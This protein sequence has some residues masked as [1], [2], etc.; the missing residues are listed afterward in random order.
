MVYAAIYHE[1]GNYTRREYLIRILKAAG[2]NLLEWTQDSSLTELDCYKDILRT[3]KKNDPKA[4]CLIVKDNTVTA[5]DGNTLKDIISRVT[6]YKFDFC[7]LANW[8]DYCQ[9][10]VKL[11]KKDPKTG[12]SIVKTQ[13]PMGNQ[14]IIFSPSGRDV[15]LGDKMANGMSVNLNGASLCSGLTE[16]VYN[17]NLSAITTIPPVFQYD[18]SLNAIRNNDYDKM[19]FC[20]PV[21]IEGSTS[22]SSSSNMLR[23]VVVVILALLVAW[24]II[25]LGPRSPKSHTTKIRQARS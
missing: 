1:D 4:H 12:I 13:H 22:S 6:R 3:A 18:I 23:F 7:Y 14:C 8:G 21:E 15:I 24:A 20:S 16:E 10:H 2:C 9:L 5:I 11:E 19:N 25:K 17:G